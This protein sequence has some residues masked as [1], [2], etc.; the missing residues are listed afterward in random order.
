MIRKWWIIWA[1]ALG[2]KADKDDKTSDIVAIVR[3]IILMIYLITNAFIVAGVI[4]H[5]SN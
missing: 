5:W 4:K 1:K 3:T 2:P